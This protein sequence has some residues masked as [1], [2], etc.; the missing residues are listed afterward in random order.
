MANSQTCGQ[1]CGLIG[2]GEAHALISPRLSI[3]WFWSSAAGEDGERTG[4]GAAD[5]AADCAEKDDGAVWFD[6]LSHSGDAPDK[7]YGFF[8]Q[9]G[10]NEVLRPL[11]QDYVKDT[12]VLVTEAAIGGLHIQAVDFM[13]WG[14]PLL[15]RDLTMRN[16]GTE[17]R[18]YQ[19]QFLAYPLHETGREREMTQAGENIIVHTRQGV[20][21]Y[22]T[23]GVVG[24]LDPGEEALARVVLAYAGAKEEALAALD[25]AEDFIPQEN[26]FFWEEWLKD[27]L[28]KQGEKRE[29]DAAYKRCLL[30]MKLLCDEDSGR[31][32]LPLPL[33]AAVLARAGVF[34]KARDR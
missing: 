13:P 30:A 4:G 23:E 16:E 7:G 32:R 21:A 3:E 8:L 2:N 22:R 20:L 28:A 14:Q 26:I 31:L 6:R 9:L 1:D 29:A 25:A 18:P 19:P 11:R 12:N 17:G 27:T 5:R 34:P 10:E 24:Y 33:A 15:I